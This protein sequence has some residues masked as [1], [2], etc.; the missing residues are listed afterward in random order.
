[1]SATSLLLSKTKK[2]YVSGP[3]KHR[4]KVNKFIKYLENDTSFNPIY[5]NEIIN[6]F[7]KLTGKKIIYPDEFTKASKLD[8]SVWKNYYNANSETFKK[9]GFYTVEGSYNF[10][11]QYYE[12]LRNVKEDVVNKSFFKKKPDYY[13]EYMKKEDENNKNIEI[14]MGLFEK[15]KDIFRYL[16]DEEA[17]D[18]ESARSK[19]IESVSVLIDEKKLEI[20]KLKLLK[21]FQ[22]SNNELDNQIQILRNDLLQHQDKRKKEQ[23]KLKEQQQQQILQQQ[24]QEKIDKLQKEISHDLPAIKEG[25]EEQ[26]EEEESIDVG[27]EEEEKEVE[28]NSKKKSFL[29]SFLGFGGKRKTKKSKRK[30]NKKKSM[31]KRKMKKTK[32]S[33]K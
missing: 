18:N 8:S 17:V 21:M 25:D 9:L 16:I 33:K 10:Y 28:S 3:D 23:Q 4:T 27:K 20:V 6:D 14:L 7:E 32:K 12:I 15:I 22:P 26:D 5:A 29:S 13:D 24:Q 31:K 30:T 19:D 11:K 1:M 2:R